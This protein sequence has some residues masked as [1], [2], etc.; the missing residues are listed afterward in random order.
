MKPNTSEILESVIWSLQTY[1]EPE[2]Q[3]PFARS[4]MLTVAN[5]L[6]HVKLRAESEPQLLAEDIRDLAA[7][8]GRATGRL[9]GE[10]PLSLAVGQAVERARGTLAE[11]G[12][13]PVPSVATL[14]ARSEALRECL[15]VL[16]Q[17]LSAVR[18]HFEDDPRYADTRQD[19]RRYLA[20]QLE[21]EGQLVTPA[22]IGGRR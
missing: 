8:L 5:L 4:V 22:F 2:L 11:P 13:E 20:R 14:A 10:A 16:L 1:V 7:V 6:R 9:G 19:I 17:A 15:D 21:R 3:S 12:V 18:E